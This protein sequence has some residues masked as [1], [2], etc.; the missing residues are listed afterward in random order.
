MRSI[1]GPKHSGL[2]ISSF[3]ISIITG[4]LMFVLIVI[5]G[6]MEVS[7]P[8]GIDENSASAVI[9]GLFIFAL[10]AVDVVALGLGIA[11]LTQKDRKQI[12]TVLGLVFSAAT[13]VGTI[14]LSVIGNMI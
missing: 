10:I 7:T 5:A 4:V 14:S 12:S 2:G 1:V 9:V 13:I 6:V 3:V 11:G 8:G